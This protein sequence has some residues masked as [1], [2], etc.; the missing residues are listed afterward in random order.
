M[1]SEFSSDG[2]YLSIGDLNEPPEWFLN[3]KIIYVQNNPTNV[4]HRKVRDSYPARTSQ[5]MSCVM[6]DDTHIDFSV[7]PS[8]TSQY[9]L[10][11]NGDS[12]DKRMHGEDRTPHFRDSVLRHY[13][14][15]AGASF[16][17]TNGE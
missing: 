3:T 16:A 13:H 5:P 8:D 17:T 9:A 2:E 10:V 15:N 1:E 6:H 14:Y 12:D 7:D 11:A 4:S